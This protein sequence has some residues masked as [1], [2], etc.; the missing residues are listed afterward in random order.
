MESYSKDN[1]DGK[2]LFDNL[3]E[4]DKDGL[5]ICLKPPTKTFTLEVVTFLQ[6]L[7]VHQHLRKIY[8]DFSEEIKEV[9]T[10]KNELQKF[11]NNAKSSSDDANK[12]IK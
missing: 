12:D 11:L 9:R 1:F 2:Q 5:I 4:T 7:M 8:K 3:F 6:N 10:L